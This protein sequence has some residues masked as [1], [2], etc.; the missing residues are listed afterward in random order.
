M[1]VLVDNYL[2]NSRTP[3]AVMPSTAPQWGEEVLTGVRCLYPLFKSL[4]MIN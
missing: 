3:S 1:A 4:Y 2:K